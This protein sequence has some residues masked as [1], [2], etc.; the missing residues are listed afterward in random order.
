MSAPGLR[1]PGS[2]ACV[3]PRREP[4]DWL[5][6]INPVSTVESLAAERGWGYRSDE[7]SLPSSERTNNDYA[8]DYQAWLAHIRER[9]RHELDAE[10][11]ADACPFT[12]VEIL[13]EVRL[14]ETSN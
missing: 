13:S 10:H 14:P 3:G 7:S 1:R 5:R 11:L 6:W 9:R 2:R 8:S 12:L 4:P